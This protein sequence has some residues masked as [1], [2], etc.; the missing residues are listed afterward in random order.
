MT[1]K[2]FTDEQIIKGLLTC[3]HK[4]SCDECPFDGA[5]FDGE[6]DCA[7]VMCENALSLINRQKVEIEA[8]NIANQKQY[9]ANT[10]QAAEIE[11]LKKCNYRQRT[12][13][14]AYHS[15]KIRVDVIKEFAERLKATLII[16]NEEN[17]EIFDYDFTL[18]TI[19]QIE[20]EMTE[21]EEK[22]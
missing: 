5:R 15:G 18:E 21:R 12:T 19:D 22:A 2:N 10:A 1:D 8:L 11:R 7:E 14:K 17:T 4:G 16:N 3:N 13:I 6:V 9:E 20:K